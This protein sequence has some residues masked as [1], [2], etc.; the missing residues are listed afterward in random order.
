MNYLEFFDSNSITTK[1]ISVYLCTILTLIFLGFLIYLCG[2]FL[3]TPKSG[4]LRAPDEKTP[5][6]LNPQVKLGHEIKVYFL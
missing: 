2:E 1:F 6:R 3:T 4:D 5:L